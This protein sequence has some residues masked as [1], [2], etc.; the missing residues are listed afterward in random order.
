[1]TERSSGSAGSAVQNTSISPPLARSVA[2]ATFWSSWIWSRNL[3]ARVLSPEAL[4]LAEP[5]SP[6]IERTKKRR[7]IV[8]SGRALLRVNLLPAKS[9]YRRT[10]GMPV[11][12]SARLSIAAT[13]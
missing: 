1:M 4:P 11:S 6:G 12:Q 7:W 8:S 9:Q 13:S 2:S 5:T 3:S 10:S